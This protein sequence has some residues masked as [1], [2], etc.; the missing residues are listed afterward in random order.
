LQRVF[1][2]RYPAGAFKIGVVFDVVD[3]FDRLR[4]ILEGA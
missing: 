4:E 2:N 1:F 3:G